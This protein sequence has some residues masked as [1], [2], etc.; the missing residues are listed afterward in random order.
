VAFARR[1]RAGRGGAVPLASRRAARRAG[2]HGLPRARGDGSRAHGR[3]RG[4]A[5]TRHRRVHGDR[6]VHVGAACCAVGLAARAGGPRRDGRRPRRRPSLRR[7]GTPAQGIRGGQHLAARV[8]C[9]AV[10]ARVP[11]GLRRLAGFD[12]AAEDAAGAGGDADRVLRGRAGADRADGAR[13]G[14]SAPWGPRARALG[15]SPGPRPRHLARRAARTPPSGRVRGE[16]GG[17]RARGRAR[18]SAPGGRRPCELRPVP[19]LQAARRGSARRRG[20]DPRPGYRCRAAGPDWAGLGTAR[21]CVAAAARAVR[22]RGG[23]ALARLRARAR[24]PRRP[25]LVAAAPRR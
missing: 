17:R 10:P 20:R 24:G 2:R 25:A 8:A 11:V 7:S 16:R 6:R 19:L 14:G 3:P 9:V 21:P 13:G 5:L 4:P 12:P 22:R 1:A 15:A 18:G 23:G